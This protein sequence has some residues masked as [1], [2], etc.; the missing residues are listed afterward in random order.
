MHVRLYGDSPEDA[1]QLPPFLEEA[2]HL[3]ER[4]CELLGQR[5]KAGF[6]RT[7]LLRRMGSTMEAG[8][9]TVEKILVE[10]EDIDEDEDDEETTAQ[11]RTLTE[12]ERGVLEHLLKSIEANQ[13]RDPKAAVVYRQLTDTRMA[14]FSGASSSPSTSTRSGGSRTSSRRNSLRRR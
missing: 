5:A 10:W 9:R 2:Y 1:I 6:F 13:E 7:I 14:G 4:F 11:L 12:E 8:R 3:A